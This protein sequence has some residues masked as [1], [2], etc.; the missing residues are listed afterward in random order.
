MTPGT[1]R[2]IDIHVKP[3]VS[4]HVQKPVFPGMTPKP[5]G[6]NIPGAP[7]RRWLILIA[8]DRYAN[9]QFLP[10]LKCC[11]PDAEALREL[12]CGRFGFAAEQTIRIYNEAA[13]ERQIRRAFE[14]YIMRA[15]RFDD[16]VV[17]SYSGHGH[18]DPVTQLGRWFAHD[19]EDPSD[20]ILNSVIRDWCKALPARHVLILADSCFS[21][22]LLVRAQMTGS[23]ELRSRE[24]ITSGGL[25]PVADA[26]SPDGQ[27]SVFNY[28]L[29]R[30]FERLAKRGEPFGTNQLYVSLYDSVYANA[31]QEPQHGVIH[32]AQHEGGQFV[33]HPAALPA[34]SEVYVPPTLDTAR[35]LKARLEKRR[36]ELLQ[37]AERAFDEA[38]E[39]DNNP[40]V[41]PV[42]KQTLW[43][44]YLEKFH[45][46]EHE[47]DY[48]RERQE[49]WRVWTPPKPASTASQ[50]QAPSS[51]FPQGRVSPAAAP[52]A[53]TSSSPQPFPPTPSPVPASLAY[54]ASAKP[55]TP[56]APAPTPRP[57]SK[58][59]AP[60]KKMEEFDEE[61]SESA[62]QS[63]EASVPVCA[64]DLSQAPGPSD[65]EEAVAGSDPSEVSAK[66]P[67]VGKKSKHVALLF[68]LLVLA[69]I[70][71]GGWRYY[72]LLLE[73]QREQVQKMEQ[74]V[75]DAASNRKARQFKVQK[76]LEQAQIL[77]QESERDKERYDKREEDNRKFR[78]EL[79]H[80]EALRKARAAFEV[81]KK[82]DGDAD[83]PAD[84]KAAEWSHYLDSYGET[85][86]EVAWAEE[87]RDFW[88]QWNPPPTMSPTPEP[89]KIWMRA[90]REAMLSATRP[91]NDPR[92]NVQYLLERPEAGTLLEPSLELGGGIIMNMVYIRGGTFIMGSSE[93]ETPTNSWDR[94]QTLIQLNRDFWMGETEV[95][96]KQWLVL[97]ENNPSIDQSDLNRPVE[98]VSWSDA[99]EFCARLHSVATSSL[100]RFLFETGYEEIVFSLPTAAQWEYACRA[101]TSTCFSFGDHD[102]DLE[103]HGWYSGNSNRRTQP[104]KTRKPNPWNL[105]DMHGNVW[106]WCLDWHSVSLPG[107]KV[108][109]WTGPDSGKDRVLRGGAANS[110]GWHCRSSYRLSSS[111]KAT[112]N[113]YGFRVVGNARSSITR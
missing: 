31:E 99:L 30:G 74:N 53:P 92:S 107:G 91:G 43:S 81:V 106:E 33:F 101:G 87:R 2:D 15:V 60:L 29:C 93:S 98:N 78:E 80:K 24:L 82:K 20:G 68:M 40:L 95:T 14:G 34:P 51:P 57:Q 102:W 36:A 25:H 76:S 13:S 103:S 111:P 97:M 104:V 17:I 47:L 12:L 100:D 108:T 61:E 16:E 89:T 46:T 26:G 66:S 86:Y 67:P 44:E 9:P 48:A 41:S 58:S 109:D 8:I 19:A 88:V 32:G 42:E 90:S 10:S 59:A 110:A 63:A 7:R 56:A 85:D 39:I 70:G 45:T 23:P 94:P 5:S 50:E 1:E 35:N 64:S 18:Y 52:A 38:D 72:L 28:Y 77:V 65:E 11:I 79:A 73:Q 75:K 3:G 71:G 6:A 83:V 62:K 69:V 112:S 37:A 55:G 54:S 22:S 105:Y 4:A 96:Q 84:V 49:H 27:H 113:I 21:G